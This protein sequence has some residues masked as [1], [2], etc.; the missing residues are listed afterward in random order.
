MFKIKVPAARFP[1]PNIFN[2]ISHADSAP[3]LRLEAVKVGLGGKHSP[4]LVSTKAGRRIV[5]DSVTFLIVVNKTGFDAD[6]RG[7]SISLVCNIGLE[8]GE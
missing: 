7:N 3:L 4:T 8:T 2:L 6:M 1:E 5:I